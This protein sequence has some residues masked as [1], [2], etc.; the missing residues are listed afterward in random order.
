MAIT[1]STNAQM[2]TINAIFRDFLTVLANFGNLI[3]WVTI[4]F[5]IYPR[6][7]IT[8]LFGSLSLTKKTLNRLSKVIVI[9]SNDQSSSMTTSDDSE[10]YEEED[11]E[12]DNNKGAQR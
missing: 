11:V 4:I 2:I 5:I 10:Y 6:Y 9:V 12:S 8:G 1:T 3:L 7:H